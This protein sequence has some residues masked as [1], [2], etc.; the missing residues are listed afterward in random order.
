MT[1]APLATWP[2]QAL[3]ALVKGYRLFFK[4]WVGDVC[5]YEP[6]CS[7]YALQALEQHGAWRGSA[8]AGAR[9]LRCHPWC[10]GGLDPIPE[11]SSGLFTGLGRAD[12]AA[13]SNRPN[14]GTPT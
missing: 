10:D 1:L 4:A 5:R 14:E 8:L 13:D 7:S 12:A 3:L 6:S 11:R 2:Q 9:L